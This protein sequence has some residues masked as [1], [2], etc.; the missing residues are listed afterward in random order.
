MSVPSKR[1]CTLMMGT[2]KPF[3]LPLGQEMKMEIAF[4]S[5]PMV[6]ALIN[7]AYAMKLGLK[8]WINKAKEASGLV[9]E[10]T[11]QKED[12]LLTPWGRRFL[13]LGPF[14][15]LPYEPLHPAVH[16][17]LHHTCN[18]SWVLWVVLVNY[19]TW[20]SIA[21]TQPGRSTSGLETPCVASIR[22]RD[23]LMELS[24]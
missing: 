19:W 9:N 6:K 8:L 20:G 13:Y 1:W 2:A 14:W 5:L 11:C 4:H 18:P 16:S 17:I 22:G 24:P 23:S 10:S 21:E 7:H 3:W 12:G 15:T